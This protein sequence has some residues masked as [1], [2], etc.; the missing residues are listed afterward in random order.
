MLPRKPSKIEVKAED[1]EELEEALRLRAS[2][3][4][5]PHPN[6]NPNPNPNPLHKLLE[7]LDP[8]SKSHRIGLQP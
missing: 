4:S 7:P 1:R 2:S 5:K 3:S 8:T 6:P